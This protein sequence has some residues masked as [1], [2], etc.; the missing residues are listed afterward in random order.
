MIPNW[1]GQKNISFHAESLIDIQPIE[2]AELPHADWHFFYSQNAAEIYLQFYH[3]PDQQ[4][5]IGCLGPAAA[6]TFLKTRIRPQFTGTGRP[7]ETG[8]YLR[9]FINNSTVLFLQ[10]SQSKNT[11]QRIIGDHSSHTSLP[12]YNNAPTPPSVDL[13][14]CNILVFTSSMNV[15]GFHL[16]HK[17]DHKKSVISIGRSTTATLREMAY[18][19]IHEAAA[20]TEEAIL[21]CIEHRLEMQDNQN[22]TYF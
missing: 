20:P 21:H 16:R 7:E 11:I 18:P 17:V 2:D 13:S 6:N 12:I 4:A 5:K 19:I 9:N 8:K 3:C 15:E 1:L 14:H 22:K 10:A